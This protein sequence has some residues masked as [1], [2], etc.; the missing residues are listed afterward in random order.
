MGRKNRT[1]IR[2]TRVEITKKGKERVHLFLTPKEYSAIKR[3]SYR[4][5]KRM[6]VQY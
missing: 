3:K 4:R 2:V 1:Y 5:F 6:K